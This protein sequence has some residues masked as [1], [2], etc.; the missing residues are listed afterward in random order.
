MDNKFNQ[1][2]ELVKQ[3]ECPVNK[4]DKLGKEVLINEEGKYP[5]VESNRK[6]QEVREGRFL[7]EH[8]LSDDENVGSMEK[9]RK[10][11]NRL[12]E[13]GKFRIW[14]AEDPMFKIQQSLQEM[15]R[16]KQAIQ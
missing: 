16:E 1:D 5:K 4:V 8:F 13:E 2:K 3:Q 15:Y 9:L 11:Y 7:D 14:E 12:I 6:S 10:R